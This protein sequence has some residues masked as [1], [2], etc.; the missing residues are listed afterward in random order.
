MH[1]AAGR[2]SIDMIDMIFAASPAALNQGGGKDGTTPLGLM[3]GM[4]L[5][6]PRDRERIMRHL[7]SLGATDKDVP[8]KGE[9]A[10]VRAAGHG[11][12]V[13]RFARAFSFFVLRAV[14]LACSTSAYNC[15]L[16][17]SRFFCTIRI[18]AFMH[19]HMLLSAFRQRAPSAHDPATSQLS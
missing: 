12:E 1:H 11:Y 10:L 13:R 7:L 9:N 19:E 8:N 2:G 17:N 16:S 3:V 6:S 18:H 15:S 4:V 14:F 5:M